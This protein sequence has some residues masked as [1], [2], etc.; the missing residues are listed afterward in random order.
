MITDYKLMLLAVEAKE[1]AGLRLT[2]AAI[3]KYA[4][5]IAQVK[6]EDRPAL[7]KDLRG[8][9]KPAT[10]VKPVGTK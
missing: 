9:I 3:H 2:K 4:P 1:K 10:R 5:K 8:L 7:A 6:Q